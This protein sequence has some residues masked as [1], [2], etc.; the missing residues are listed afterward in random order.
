[1]NLRC[2]SEIFLRATGF[3][4]RS[5]VRLI[6][7]RPTAHMSD[8]SHQHK[9]RN[10]RVLPLCSG[11]LRISSHHTHTHRESKK[12]VV[13]TN[14]IFFG[15]TLTHLLSP[16]IVSIVPPPIIL[17][18]RVHIRTN[19]R[20][21]RRDNWLLIGFALSVCMSLCWRS[22]GVRRAFVVEKL[23]LFVL[24]TVYT[25]SVLVKRKLWRE[26]G[27]VE[28]GRE[29]PWASSTKLRL[30]SKLKVRSIN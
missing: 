22:S 1:M 25:R 4:M 23:R 26:G 28:W 9:Q 18:G 16:A 11:T 6:E 13:L 5:L 15:K 17:I 27:S 21:N 8:R 14:W 3:Y 30:C 2:L 12:A 20:T 7:K 19:Y 10:R 24:V 29:G